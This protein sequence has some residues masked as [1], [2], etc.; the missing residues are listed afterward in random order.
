MKSWIWFRAL[1]VVLAIFTLGHT[2]GTMHSITNTS[3][4]GEV[5]ARMQQYRVPVMGFLRSYWEFYRGFSITISILLAALMVIAWQLGTLSRRNPREAVPFAF[6][7][8]LACVAN[9]I[10]SF[11]YFFTAP[12]AIST[13]ALIC[14]AVGFALTRREVASAL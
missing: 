3:D 7:V 10:V 11:L 12:M 6:T 8:L 4:E 1:A 2:V 9:A 5:I 14:A 13:I